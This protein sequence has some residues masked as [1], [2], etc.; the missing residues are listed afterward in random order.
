[1]TTREAPRLGTRVDVTEVRKSFGSVRAID[2][3]DLALSPAS[4]TALL[5]PSGCGKSTLLALLAGLERPDSGEIRLDDHP[6]GH[7]PAEHRPVGL[8]FQKPLLFPHLNV[9]DNVAFGLRMQRRPHRHARAR[10]RDLLEQV[11][12]PELAVRRVGEL[13]GGQEQRVALARALAL[14]PRLLLLDEPF[15]QLDPDLRAR[16]RQLVRTLSAEA[17]IT[18][19]FVTHDLAEAVDV[20]DEIVLML[21]GRVEGQGSPERFYR[22]PPTLEAARFFEVANEIAG[23]C[24]RGMFHAPGLVVPLRLDQ[25]VLEGPAVLVVRPESMRLESIPAEPAGAAAGAPGAGG[26]SVRAYP[27][28]V[29]FAGTHLVLEACTDDGSRLLAHLPPGTTVADQGPVQLRAAAESCTLFPR[30]S[31]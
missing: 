17:K 10:A 31:A 30:P 6:V 26:L 11:G 15:S 2:R 1:M 4:F 24:E 25:T 19:L 18:T 23:R 14:R 16:M 12:L 20:A 28:G 29:R 5:G 13:S 9:L 21:D 8:V 3:V 22:D 7:L 27:L